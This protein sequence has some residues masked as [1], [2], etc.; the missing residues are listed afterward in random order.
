[1]NNRIKRIYLAIYKNRVVF[2]ST[3][4][5]DFVRSMG[6]IATGM[7]QYTFYHKKFKDQDMIEHVD[8]LGEIYFFQKIEN[9]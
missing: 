9:N 2:V 4:L 8:M 7:R 1:M 3:S 6:A 5:S